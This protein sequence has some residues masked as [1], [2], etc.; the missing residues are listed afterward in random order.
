MAHSSNLSSWGLVQDLQEK[1]RML[2]APFLCSLS[3]QSFCCTS[4]TV[5][6]ACVCVKTAWKRCGIGHEVR[7]EPSS[8]VSRWLVMTEGVLRGDLGVYTGLPMP[9]CNQSPWKASGQ[10]WAKHMDKILPSR[11]PFP[12]LFDHFKIAWRIW[13]TN[14]IC[15][16]TDFQGTCKGLAIHAIGVLSYTADKSTFST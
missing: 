14:Q 3:K 10:K 7:V 8:A 12:S 1:V 5:Q 15:P 13:T 16:I 9:R 6:C 11:S 4:L 2:G